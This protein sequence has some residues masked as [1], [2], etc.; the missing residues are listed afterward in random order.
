[1]CITRLLYTWS[2]LTQQI[3]KDFNAV[4]FRF[5]TGFS[6]I[7][8][9]LTLPKFFI[10]SETFTSSCACHPPTTQCS[11]EFLE[12]DVNVQSIAN[13]RLGCL[14]FTAAIWRYISIHTLIH[15]FQSWAKSEVKSYDL[16]AFSINRTSHSH[17]VTHPYEYYYPTRM[18][19]MG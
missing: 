18:R 2:L 7:E 3:M 15:S 16:C 6:F 8:H 19:S 11:H 12:L 10:P 5:H 1:M 9:A 13:V 17:I 14:S 4:L